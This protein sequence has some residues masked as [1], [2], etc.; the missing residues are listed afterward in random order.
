MTV[1]DFVRKY[2]ELKQFY[3]HGVRRSAFLVK[4]I[5]S[6]CVF[7]LFDSEE[8]ADKYVSSSNNMTVTEVHIA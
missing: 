4:S 1:N 7:G 5:E 8:K 6:G 3:I 2:A